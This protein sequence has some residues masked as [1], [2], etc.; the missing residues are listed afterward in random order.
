V[1]CEIIGASNTPT[2]VQT[3]MVD[4]SVVL[5]NGSLSYTIPEG[6]FTNEWSLTYLATYNGGALPSWLSFDASTR[7]FSGVP[8]Q[9]GAWDIEVTVNDGRGGVVSDTVRFVVNTN[10]VLANAMGEKLFIRGGVFNYLIP[11]STFTDVEGHTLT[12]SA[13]YNGGA[14]PSWVTLDGS[15][16][17]FSGTLPDSIGSW[18]IEVRGTDELGGTVTDTVVFKTVDFSGISEELEQ[19][20]T[21][22]NNYVSGQDWKSYFGCSENYPE[23]PVNIN[24]ILLGDCPFSSNGEKVYETHMLYL[25]PRSCSGVPVTIQNQRELWSNHT[26]T[27]PNSEHAMLA[28]LSVDNIFIKTESWSNRQVESDRWVLMYVGETVSEYIFEPSLDDGVI[29][30]SREKSWS[31]QQSLFDSKNDG[32]YEIV[33]SLEVVTGV[34]MKYI[35]TGEKILSDDRVPPTFTRTMDIWSQV[36]Y[37]ERVVV[38]AFDVHGLGVL[39]FPDNID[40][41]KV[42][43]AVSRNCF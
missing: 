29:P 3:P 10:P 36:R 43:V 6:T 42:A 14:L 2:V 27:M 40:G 25:M 26:E 35:K 32:N 24:N 28:L 31:E 20:L 41:S 1:T 15:T 19:A 11:S 12:Y 34:M 16:G 9:A 21:N 38:G 8:P 18:A 5:P 22:R 13:T 37:A 39:S 4:P 33:K 30:G 7:T 17:R 23:V